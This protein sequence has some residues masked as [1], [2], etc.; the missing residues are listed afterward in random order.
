MVCAHPADR[1]RAKQAAAAAM[2]AG[3]AIRYGFR[4]AGDTPDGN[5][6]WFEVSG[7]A[8]RDAAGRL[9]RAIGVTADVTERKRV[10]RE[11]EALDRQLTE[12]RRYDSLGLLAGGIAHDFNN[13][14]TTILG[15]AGLARADVPP[16]SSTATCL[17][18]IEAACQRA[19]NLCSQLTAYA[20]VGRL[21]V[22]PVD[23]AALL[24][25]AEQVLRADAGRAAVTIRA[26]A[27]LPPV[28]GEAFQI[29]QAIRNLVTNAGEAVGTADG[30][31]LIE[32][33]ETAIP[34]VNPVSCDDQLPP[35]AP[36]R[37]LLVR[38]TDTGGGM[39]PDTAG[40][41]FDPFFSTKF[42]GRGLGLA[43]VRGIV[44]GH[45]GGIRLR[46]TP[47]EGT[48]L[49]LLLPVATCGG[50]A[51]ISVA[52]DSSVVSAPARR[53]RPR[54]GP[55]VLVVDDEANIRDLI[56]SLLEDD[57]LTVE[58]SGDGAEAVRVFARDPHRYALA[59]VD[60]IMPGLGGQDVIRELR[61]LRPGLPT[62]VV[63][64]FSD[65]ELPA[66]VRTGGPTA[67]LP[68]PFRIDQFAAVVNATLGTS[69]MSG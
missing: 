32:V 31:V 64:G 7:Q 62:V 45:K 20:G 51:V 28:T 66:D 36:G 68:K 13:L 1:D 26:P 6:R 41:A 67:L 3:G 58:A 8:M 55:H 35:P 25:Q 17:A 14:L 60:L 61:A 43:A 29:R 54:P 19:A 30:A 59:V 39:T 53:P 37:Y 15:N 12:A 40:R 22:G 56:A 50:D 63:S 57:G 2:A 48:T 5:P 4:G 27:D 44:K 46:S 9:M 23:L 10:E 11:R 47:G 65:R 34:F 24:R 38:V 21:A 69:G 42:A 33:E 52:T 16:G 49:E 18:D